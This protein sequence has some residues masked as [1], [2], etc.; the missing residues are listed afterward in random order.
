MIAGR[1]HSNDAIGHRYEANYDKYF[2]HRTQSNRARHL[3]KTKELYFVKYIFPDLEKGNVNFHRRIPQGTFSVHMNN[4][5]SHNGLKLASKVE[6]HHVSRLPYS[7]YSLDITPCDFW[8]FGMLKGVLKDREF[9][10]SD[11]IDRGLQRFGIR[12]VLMKYR[13]SST[14]G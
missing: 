2:P 14:T 9:D 8:L 4:S 3:T 11:E 5:M 10:S 12:S 6:D 1:C 13:A 7:P